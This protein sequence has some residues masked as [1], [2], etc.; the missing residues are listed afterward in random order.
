M[1]EAQIHRLIS[2]AILEVSLTGSVF[3]SIAGLY[4]MGTPHVIIWD[5]T[6]CDAAHI[7]RKHVYFVEFAV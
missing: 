5:V 3:Y 4:V 6:K 2:T 1:P 7:F